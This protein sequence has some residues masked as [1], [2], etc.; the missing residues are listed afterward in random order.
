MGGRA[1]LLV[2]PREG[3]AFALLAN[4]E[5]SFGEAEALAFARLVL[6]R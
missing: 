3:V 2:Y 1:F 5:A 6:P 4:T